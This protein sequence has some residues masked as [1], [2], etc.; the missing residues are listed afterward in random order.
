MPAAS[1][2]QVKLKHI[3]CLASRFAK[4][5]QITKG[6]A[7][8]YLAK[9]R[10]YPSWKK[11][12]RSMLDGNYQ[13]T[14]KLSI[15]NYNLKTDTDFLKQSFSRLRGISPNIEGGYQIQS[16]H[17]FLNYI[18]DD[19]ENHKEIRNKLNTSIKDI[20]SRSK[21]HL[22]IQIYLWVN[23]TTSKLIDNHENF[24]NL[25]IERYP[26]VFS[27]EV[28]IRDEQL[29]PNELQLFAEQVTKKNDEF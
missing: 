19:F 17:S 26:Q 11:L 14:S 12:R 24:F 3:K 5:N 9:Q 15:H 29:T 1:N 6:E 20:V 4:E 10:G 21:Q 27:L 25:L 28:I 18:G 22:Y 7:L 16:R 2:R 13:D 8:E 23:E